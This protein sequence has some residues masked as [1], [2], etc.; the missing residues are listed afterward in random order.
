MAI[1]R[2]TTDEYFNKYGQLPQ[3]KVEPSEMPSTANA[4][5][6][7]NAAMQTAAEPTP[8]WVQKQISNIVKDVPDDFREMGENIVKGFERRTDRLGGDIA[9]RKEDGVSLREQLGTGLG[10]ATVTAQT[11]LDAVFEGG[12]FVGKQFLTEDQEN[13][14]TEKVGQA[15]EFGLEATEDTAPRELVEA[16]V[17]GYNKWAQDNP[18]EAANVRD[19][20]GLALSFA[21]LAGYKIGAP[22]AKRTVEQAGKQAADVITKTAKTSQ[23]VIEQ[24]ARTT[25]RAVDAFA[26]ARR[27]AR[28][29]AQQQKAQTAVARITQAGDDPRK[30]QQATRALTEI[31]TT[32]VKTYAELNSRLDDQIGVLSTQVDDRLLEDTRLYTA[33]DL[34]RISEVGGEVITESPVQNALDGLERAYDLSGEPANAA[35]IRQL[36]ER[37]ETD[38]ITLKEA[39]DLARE[40][41]VEF[42]NRAFT[43]LGEQKQ[44]YNADMYENTRKSLKGVIRDQ[45]PDDVTKQIDQKISDIYTTLD[46]TSKRADAVAKLEQKIKNRNL[47]QKIWGAVADVADVATF[48]GLR[49]FTMRILPSNVGNKAM[50]AIDI[51]NELRKNL[52]EIQKL[53]AIQD[54]VKFEAAMTEYVKTAQPGLSIRSSVTPLSVA[55]KMDVEDFN[56]ITRIIDEGPDMARLDP[57]TNAFLKQLGLDKAEPDELDRFLKEATDEYERLKQ[58]FNQPA[59]AQTTDLLSQAKGKTLDEFKKSQ[60][61]VYHG[62]VQPLE[63][64]DDRGAWFTDDMMNADGY[65]GGQ[66]VFE[67][68]LDMKKPLVIDAKGRHHFDLKTPYGTD[69]QEVVSK[70]EELGNY[71]GVIFKNINDNFA[72]DIDLAGQDTIFYPFNANKQF[73]NESQLED[74]WKKANK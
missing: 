6:G 31:D 59:T 13:T 51:Q 2:M 70:V 5:R 23:E 4:T 28:L 29:A 22:V 9:R 69:T 42:K 53:N 3:L 11:A 16:T 39:N 1:K 33:N 66:N 34:V 61:V 32:N 17:A 43:K 65:A 56:R 74:I 44:G 64:F 47:T 68:Y 71:D 60:T 10:A 73:I 38:G 19:V 21:E 45:M 36:R 41:G 24:G 54:P 57:D 67:G 8:T 18:E 48:G 20:T 49:G 46:L 25:G 14:I 62:S 7:Y 27:P 72:D 26:D 35:R 55:E 52:K 63:K 30:I 50:N 58:S 15:I 40:Y 12:M 37:F